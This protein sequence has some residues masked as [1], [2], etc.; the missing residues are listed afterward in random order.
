MKDLSSL[1][2][3]LFA[4]GRDSGCREVWP[5]AGGGDYCFPAQILLPAQVVSPPSL[6]SDDG[7]GDNGRGESSTGD[8]RADE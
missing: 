1:A 4:M 2:H 6:V 8:G 3:V 5:K 7:D